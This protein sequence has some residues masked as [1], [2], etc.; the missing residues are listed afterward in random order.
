M[1][2]CYVMLTCTVTVL[3]TLHRL[4]DTLVGVGGCLAYLS[5]ITCAAV[6]SVYLQE[7]AQ[8]TANKSD[9]D[10]GV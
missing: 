5:S 8:V 4:H 9:E 7:V 10:A 6:G 3:Q 2:V 1:G